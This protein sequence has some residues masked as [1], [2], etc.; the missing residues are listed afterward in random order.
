[1][2]EKPLEP[3]YAIWGE[4]RAKVE[5]AVARLIGRVESEGGLPAERYDATEIPSSE[6]VGACEA[7]SLAGIRLVVLE[8]ASELKSADARPIVDYLA[9]PNPG[10]CLAIV[11]STPPPGQLLEAVKRVGSEL[12]YGPGTKATRKERMAWQVAHVEQEVG[13]FGAAIAPD[14]ARAVVER[15]VVDRPEAHKSGANSLQL[16]Q[17]SRKLAAAAAGQRIDSSMVADLVAIHP[18]ARAYLLSDALLAGKSSDSLRLLDE[19]ATGDDPVAPIVIQATLARQLRAVVEACAL[20]P[21]A[22]VDAVSEVT[23]QS[24][25]PARKTLDQSRAISQPAAERAFAR[26]A[27]LELELR[28]SAARELGRSRDDGERLVIERAARDVIEIVR[29]DAADPRAGVGAA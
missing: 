11:S 8:Q 29:A 1:M 7:L 22:D 14:A 6:V 9:N 25:F 18:D 26:V 21:G 17:E 23:G 13:R 5:R 24:G 20:G 15:V 28:V 27:A 16:T 4:D 12:V 19:L 3:V 10:T 2:A